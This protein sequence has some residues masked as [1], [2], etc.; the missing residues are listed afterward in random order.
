MHK[1]FLTDSQRTSNV[2]ATYVYRISTYS[3]FAWRT[4]NLLSVFKT[5][6]ERTRNV[7][8]TYG[9]RI[10]Q[11]SRVQLHIRAISECNAPV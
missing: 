7:F 3:A 2:C 4:G 9:K 10:C 8:I 11:C 1:V 5:Y 6:A